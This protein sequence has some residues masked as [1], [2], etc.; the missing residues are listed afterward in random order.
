[1]L[2]EAIKMKARKT[3]NKEEVKRKINEK[4]NIHFFRI[5]LI[6]CVFLTIMSLGIARKAIDNTSEHMMPEIAEMSANSVSNAI[7]TYY[8]VVDNVSNLDKICNPN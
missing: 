8:A 1:M 7:N 6:V 5:L 3:K 2:K 4:L